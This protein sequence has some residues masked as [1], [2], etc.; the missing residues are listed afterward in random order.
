MAGKLV[1]TD[2]NLKSC[3]AAFLVNLEVLFGYEGDLLV[4]CLCA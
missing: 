3:I 2:L 1:Q 4:G